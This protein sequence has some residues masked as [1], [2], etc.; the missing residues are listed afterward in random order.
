MGPNQFV[1]AIRKLPIAAV[2]VFLAFVMAGCG[3]GSTGNNQNAPTWNYTALGDSLAAGALAQQGYVARY[4]TYVNADTGANVTTVNLGVPGWHSA[5]L[6]NA[7]QNDPTLRASVSNA[8]VVTFDIGGN[9][10]ASGHDSYTGGTCGGTDGQDCL[11]A[12]VAGFE[13]NWDEILAQ[14]LTLR[15]TG[16][17]I[18]RTMDIYNPYVA[19]DMKAGIFTIMEPYLDE[20]NTHIHSTAQANGIPVAAVHQAFNGADGTQ[21][22]N[23]Q[24]LLAI[25]GFHPNDAG[26][27]V[28]ADQLRAL[29][30]AP[31][32]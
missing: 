22:P 24:G 30:Y 10:L 4:A 7:L 16:N 1:A 21:D 23:V 9:D 17:T 28:I 3:S 31:L 32:H 11:R 2:L 13:T 26:H 19:A 8:E 29:G 6:L 20:V 18:I 27:K 12:A 25:D 15:S 14:L 5:D